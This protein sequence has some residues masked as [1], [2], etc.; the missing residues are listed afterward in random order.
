MLKRLL[1]VGAGHS[2]LEVI[3][4]LK[5]EPFPNVEVCLLS[6]S[7]YQYYSGMFS[8]YTEGLYGLD[9]TRV[10]LKELTDA[11][12]VHFVKKMVDRVLPERKKIVCKDR[13]VYPFD[14]ISFDIGSRSLPHDMEDTVARTIKPNY[15]FVDQINHLRETHNPLLVGGGAAGSELAMS[16]QAYKERKQ[17]PGQVRLVSANRLLAEAPKRVSKKLE[18]LITK[19]GIQVWEN[20][21][22]VEIHE[23]HIKTEQGNRIRHTGVLWLGG[24]IADPIFK[25]SGIG[26]DERGFAYVKDTLQFEDYTHIFGAGDCVTMSSYPD[27]AKSGVYAVRQGPVL[28]EN[29]KNYLSEGELK[30]YQPQSQALYILSTGHKKGFFTYGLV[31]NHSHRAWKLKN[32]ID[33]QFMNKYK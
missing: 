20:E 26:H 6:P 8:G 11:A 2:H 29:L 7:T 19:K 15:E 24:A 21:R 32:K 28:W 5:E 9:D 1:L 33:T 31:T 14:V 18:S 3:R 30:A 17:I 22:V 4:K 25:S 27:L 23:H 13:S 16:I 10:N 12:G